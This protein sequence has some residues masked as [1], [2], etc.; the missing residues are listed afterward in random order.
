MGKKHKEALA[1]LKYGIMDNRGL[2]MLTGDIG[3]G[4]TTLLNALKETLCTD[5]IT[6]GISNP[7]LEKLD[8]LNFLAASFGLKETFRNKGEFLL[9]F[10]EFLETCYHNGKQVLLII[11]EAQLLTQEMLDEIRLLSNIERKD[12]KLLNIFFVGQDELNGILDRHENR[13]LLQRITLNYHLD[14]LDENE[15]GEFIEY[16]LKVAGAGK[17]IFTRAAIREIYSFSKGYPR[18]ANTI[19]D[20]A[21][22]TG[23]AAKK[24]IIGVDE[25]RKCAINLKL[26]QVNV[27]QPAPP[28]PPPAPEATKIQKE[29]EAALHVDGQKE[30]NFL[31]SINNLNLDHLI[32][33]QVGT[34]TL[35]KELSRG[36]M[37]VIFAAYQKSLKR[38]IAVKILPKSILTSMTA[39]SFQQKAELASIL[40][41]PNIV[42]IYEIGDT[43]DF[44]FFTMQLVNGKPLSD[45][46]KMVRKHLLPSKRI[47]PLQ[48]TLT[49][50][51]SVL[52]ALDYAHSQD[53]LHRGIKPAKILIETPTNRTILTDF[54]VARLSREPN[55]ISKLIAGTPIY[56]APE[57]IMD[58]TV[59]ERADI[60]SAAMILF[61]M[62]VSELPLPKASTPKKLLGMRWSLKD[63]FF[64]K[65]PSELNPNIG[66]EMDEIVLK[67]LSFYPEKRYATIRAFLQ[68]LEQYQARH[69]KT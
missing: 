32:G 38:Q 23:Y 48:E 22:L 53:I 35:L 18:L 62:L 47:L 6:A 49:I 8:F 34:A 19:C 50:I 37:G 39:E 36:G 4:K 68:D 33:H 1:M 45:R 17:K 67:A 46:L 25:I 58:E 13:A 30:Q 21:M 7:D 15:I 5:V 56:M 60:Y 24:K 9:C 44:L 27:T 12:V 54:G 66:K 16:R 43:K 2:I 69:V 57:Q 3:T 61:E 41:H 52:D 63:R 10:K 51:G 28:S 65:R 55:V 29:P 64:Q 20:H 11:D 31:S 59:D 42:P 26:P 40:S 14:P